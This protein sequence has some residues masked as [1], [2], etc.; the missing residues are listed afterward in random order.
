MLEQSRF[1]FGFRVVGGRDQERRLTDFN[2]AFLAHLSNDD[3]PPAH[4]EVPL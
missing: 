3:S 4:P 2:A 1:R